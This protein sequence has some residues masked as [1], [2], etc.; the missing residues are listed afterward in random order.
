[1]SSS[2]AL[3]F[4]D[5][6][7]F[8]ARH[9]P[10]AV[11]F[12]SAE[13]GASLT[14]AQT[15]ARID[16]LAGALRARYSVGQGDRVLHLSRTTVE[17]FEVQFACARIGAIFVPLNWRLSNAELEAIA[18]DAEPA[19]I[20]HQAE[21]ESA[22]RAMGER[23]RCPLIDF[24][25]TGAGGS[26][27]AIVEGES[28]PAPA[29]ELVDWE[30]TWIVLY[31]SG[32]TGR[33]KGAML[34]YRMMYFNALNF[35]PT[36]KLSTDT[37]FLCCMPTFHTGGLNC[38]AN[39]VLFCG[40]TVVVMGEFNAE[41]ALGLMSDPSMGIT[42]FFGVPS[43]YLMLSELPSFVDA[44]FPAFRV[45]GLGGAPA[46]ESLVD[47]W[48]SKGVPLQPAY[49]MTEIGPAIA[50]STIERVRE[51]IRS[52][53]QPV[54][55][56]EFRIADAAGCPVK[57]GEV[58]ELQVKGPVV[59]SGYWRQPEQTGKAFKDGWFCT[60]DAVRL[61]NDGFLYIVDRYKDMYISG[62]ENVYPTEVENAL[63]KHPSV[64]RSAVIGVADP[65]WGEVGRAYVVLKGATQLTA[66]ALNAHLAGLLAD[67]KLPRSYAFVKDLP[68]TASGKVKKQD[69]R[70]L[71]A[72]VQ[73]DNQGTPMG[74]AK[75]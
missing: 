46:T 49:G 44:Q 13:S 43:M 66:D 64:L 21:F 6:I 36:A 62:G 14:Y 15:N 2:S 27:E 63:A 34:S 74:S 8:H 16:A 19:V 12:R 26:Y 73:P 42:H 5:W 45:A 1:M 39:P 4:H 71:A 54:M 24:Q 11:A 30:T 32:T 67:F 68:Q 51:K 3:K 25:G 75:S 58:G 31:T 7:R 70:A 23:Q 22:A 37:V 50:V 61:D 29:E 48:L 28:G 57:P 60:G 47:K 40:G 53:G 56:I 55:N 41:R 10:H 72:G 35:I 17:A 9:H 65:K 52:V 38:Y 33:P 69:L 59:M 20:V 18:G